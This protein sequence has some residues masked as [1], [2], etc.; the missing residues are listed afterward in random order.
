MKG[1]ILS[2]ADCG[3]RHR[4]EYM[5]KIC[6]CTCI[7]LNSTLTSVEHLSHLPAPLPADLKKQFFIVDVI[8]QKG[9]VLVYHSQFTAGGAH[10]QAAH[11][12]WQLQQCNGERVV[13]KYLQNLR[14]WE[15]HKIITL[16]C[17]MLVKYGD[18]K[19]K[20]TKN[21]FCELL[22]C[23]HTKE[24]MFLVLISGQLPC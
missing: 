16:S 20:H 19:W 15:L 2:I 5:S 14:Q 9:V 13:N 10:V 11:W 6:T 3:M 7:L 1:E 22:S 23:L 21:V 4:Q 24:N 8:D 12:R 18:I 17:L